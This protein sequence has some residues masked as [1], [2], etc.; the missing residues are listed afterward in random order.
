V[1]DASEP[2]WAFTCASGLP[3]A[4]AA[5]LRSPMLLNVEHAVSDRSGRISVSG[6]AASFAP[7]LLVQVLAHDHSL[8]LARIGLKRDDIAQRYPDYPNARPPGF[9]F[10]IA[11]EHLPAGTPITVR[12]AARSGNACE[13]VLPLA[14]KSDERPAISSTRALAENCKLFLDTPAVARDRNEAGHHQA[15]P[16]RLGFGARRGSVD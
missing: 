9:A 16:R 8:G 6:W 2:D 11:G 5:G 10:S 12:A 7:M 15:A 14:P 4:E 1:I 13:F 3:E